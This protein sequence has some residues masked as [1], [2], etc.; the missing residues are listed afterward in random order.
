[1]ARIDRP[2][3][4]AVNQQ[5]LP[6]RAAQRVDG[7]RGMQVDL[8]IP[9][10]EYEIETAAVLRQHLQMPGTDVSAAHVFN[11]KLAMRNR[12]RAASIPVPEYSPVFN[13]DALRAFMRR[14]PGP[15]LLKPRNEAGA[16]GIRRVEDEE[17]LWRQLDILADK[18]SWSLLEKFVPSDVF[19]VDSVVCEGRIVFSAV[20]GYGRPPLAVSHGG[21]VFTSRTLGRDSSV[22]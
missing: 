8:I 9:L 6:A 15:W 3:I 14:V 10:D 1:M 11:D 18:Q 20:S 12:A 5:H 21:G 7:A 13:Y 19:H 4:G 2:V 17:D 22:S 16:M